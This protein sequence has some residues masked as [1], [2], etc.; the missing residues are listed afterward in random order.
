MLNVKVKRLHPDAVL[1]FYATS[2]AAAVDIVAVDVTQDTQPLTKGALPSWWVSTGLAMEIP[3]GWCLKLYPRSGLGCKHHTRLANCVGI[4][5]SDYRGEI[6]AKLIADPYAPSTDIEP[7]MAVM[8][9]IFERAPQALL[10]D[11]FDLGHSERG[12]NGFGSTSQMPPSKAK[13]L[14]LPSSALTLAAGSISGLYPTSKLLHKTPGGLM[15]EIQGDLVSVTRPAV[16]GLTNKTTITPAS[17]I[18]LESAD[19]SDA[20]MWLKEGKRT[21]RKGWNGKGLW[22]ELKKPIIGSDMTLP[23][24]VICY[25][26]DAQNTP[27][28][29]AP[30]TP[31]QTDLLANDWHVVSN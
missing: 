17:D 31:S 21:A 16:Y 19:F 24:L 9:G 11:V 3:P 4:I 30:W 22:L 20:L 28:A 14:D 12:E 7:G 1:P 26:A 15:V 8:Q 13:C 25:P 18:D 27:G 6:K 2:G 5:D 23:Y 29:R 10:V